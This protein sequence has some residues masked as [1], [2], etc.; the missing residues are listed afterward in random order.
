MKAF[1]RLEMRRMVSSMRFWL[2]IFAGCVLTIWQYFLTSFAARNNIYFTQSSPF[3]T[4]QP[5]TWY[6]NWIGGELHT[7]Q[8]YVYFMLIPVWSVLSYSLT[9]FED[10]STGYT[11]QMFTRGKKK[12]Y[13]TAKY[14]ATFLCGGIC[15]VFPLVVNLYLSMCTLPS[16][17]PDSSTGTQMV[18]GGDMWFRLF[19]THPNLYELA[20]LVLIFVFSGL[21]A[22]FGMTVG[23]LVYN[24]FLIAVIPLLLYMFLH[25]IGMTFEGA[26]RFSPFEFLPPAVRAGHTTFGATA[27]VTS[28]LFFVTTVVYVFL[29]SK[30]EVI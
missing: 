10:R 14:L 18:N 11:S 2:I 29:A 9:L 27:L 1:F 17:L 15:S 12:D 28:I 8:G 22:V 3:V 21:I 5:N 30:D 6:E 19:Y 23:L 16:I 4:L 7:M 25:A 26:A 20:H 24:R 13:Y